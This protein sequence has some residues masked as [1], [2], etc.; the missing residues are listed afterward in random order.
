MGI[1]ASDAN[2]FALSSTAPQYRRAP[3]L[4]EHTREIMTDILGMSPDDYETLAADGVF[5]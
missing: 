4:G 3:L 5:D 2:C 1:Y